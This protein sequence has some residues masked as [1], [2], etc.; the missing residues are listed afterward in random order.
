[1]SERIVSISH[2]E[3][4]ILALI[5]DEIDLSSL[6]ARMCDDKVSGER[7]DKAADNVA[8]LIDNMMGRRTHKLPKNHIE[9]K[10]K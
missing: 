3:Y 10:E 2:G 9:Y 8:G 4:E 6:K 1:M 5:L 7:F